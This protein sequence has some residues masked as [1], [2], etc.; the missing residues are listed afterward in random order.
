MRIVQLVLT[1]QRIIPIAQVEDAAAAE[2][3]A[4]DLQAWIR[5][6]VSI[7]PVLGDSEPIP[8][9][10]IA[11]INVVEESV[12]IGKSSPL[13]HVRVLLVDDE[14]NEIASLRRALRHDPWQLSHAFSGEEALRALE[15]D[16]FDVVIS[17]ISMRGMSGIELLEAVRVQQPRIVRVLLSG[18]IESQSLLDSA[19]VADLHLC[20]PCTAEQIKTKVMEAMAA[21]LERR[22][23]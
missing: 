17:D 6:G 9:E 8:P 12:R 4:Q 20:K 23:A 22:G 5:R 13:G 11:R 1:D 19:K 15:R 21:R 14:Y 10:R 7:R 2:A 18:I 16:I 3:V